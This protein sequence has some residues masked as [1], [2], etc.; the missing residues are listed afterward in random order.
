MQFMLTGALAVGTILFGLFP[1][2]FPAAFAKYFGIA[3]GEN[4]TVA[5]A[6]RSV[7]IR[8]AMIGIGLVR[9]LQV[10]DPGAI[11]QWLLA[12]A[13]S[14]AGDAIAVGLAVAAGERNPRFL[15]LGSLAAGAAVVGGVLLRA[16]EGSRS[17]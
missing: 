11:R 15:V 8:D 12:R 5:T 2:I 6:I 9:S 1:A 16:N 3:A 14:D 7:G 13:A 10:G 4:P 17:N